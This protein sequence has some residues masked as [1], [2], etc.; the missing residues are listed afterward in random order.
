MISILISF[1]HDNIPLYYVKMQNTPK[2][3]ELKVNWD[4][5]IYKVV[6]KQWHE[7]SKRNDTKYHMTLV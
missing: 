3:D 6:H 4:N 7:I 2:M 5:N 1:I